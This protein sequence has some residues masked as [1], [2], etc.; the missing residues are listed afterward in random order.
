MTTSFS[1]SPKSRPLHEGQ[2]AAGKRRRKARE[3]LTGYIFVLPATVATLVFGLWPVVAGF[4]ESIKSGSPLTNRY[5]GLNNYLRSLGS[6][7]FILL[8]VLSLLFLYI[9]YRAWRDAYRHARAAGSNLWVYIVPGLLCGA[10]SIVLA[11]NVVTGSERYTWLPVVLLLLSLA[12]F[13]GADQ[14]QAKSTW[15]DM[16]PG[17]LIMVAVGA[18]WIALPRVLPGTIGT[19]I[20]LVVL[21]V[22]GYLL[23][24]LVARIRTGRYISASIVMGI[25]MLLAILLARYTVAQMESTTQEA[26]DIAAR[27][28]NAKVLNTQVDVTDD[29]TR[30]AGLSPD[31]EIIVQVNVNGETIEAPLAPDAFTE[32][33]AERIT[34][35]ETALSNNQKVQVILPDGTVAEGQITGLPMGQQL[36]VELQAQDPTAVRTVSIYS[37]LDVGENVIRAGGQ[38]E[39][40]GKQILAS[41]AVAL[42]L[43]TIY[44]ISH[45][46]RTVDDETQP[47]LYRWLSVGRALMGILVFL[48]FFY[49]LGAVQLNRQAAAAMNALSEEQFSRAYQVVYDTA[50]R[51]TLRAEVLTAQLL[52]WPQVLLT[53]LGALILGAAY[54]VWQS[55]QQRETK[56]GFGLTIMLAVM[57]MVGGWLTISE[58]P[59]TM[60]MAGREAKD[61]FD[62]LLRTALYSAGTVPVQ[63]AL[64]LFLAYLLFSEITWGKSLFRVI[65]F[66]PYIAPSVATATVF[67]VIFSLN[68]NSLANQ[69]LKLVGLEPLVWLKEPTG[70]IRLFYDKVLG[71][72]PLNI[73]SALQGP[74][75]ALT[76]VILYNIWV[77]AGYNTV[78]FL[79][80][81]GAIPPELY[82]AAQ[83]DGA[84]R[85][86]RFRY[87]TL[88]LLSPT[89][90]FLS[91]LAVIGT[92]KA[93]THIYVLREQAVGK[94]IDT[95]SVH[96]FTNLYQAN[97]PGYAAALAFTLFGVIL[98]LT[99][100]QNRLAREQVFYG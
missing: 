72:D 29:T 48:G 58:L 12:G 99:L 75:L 36:P 23:L 59:D 27:I 85:W 11:F 67:L 69:G 42:G 71:G 30:I 54:L 51:A 52:Y 2:L 26:Q 45:V 43:A 83:V 77:F 33:P 79:A 90:F 19:L 78:V 66:M 80:G 44:T 28:F 98:V 24:P 61:T 32:L 38:T 20:L 92:F 84:G 96:I 15:R 55:A 57:M 100:V 82:E 40:L 3:A 97:D 4:Y 14:L 16:L 56:L 1:P 25:T 49:I 86:S 21:A 37:A 87:I 89:T 93:F 8:F 35:L 74:S 34:R 18:A 10:G 70:I 65:Y 91:M 68:E 41:L 62:A 5:V 17:W 7:T 94:E 64:G 60:N 9:G 39:P 81:L 76:T 31:G 47:K 88:P 95:M 46:R 73:P 22:L 13:Y 53:A 50:P 63:L 6:L